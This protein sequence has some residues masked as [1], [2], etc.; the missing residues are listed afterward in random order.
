[1]SEARVGSSDFGQNSDH[2][3]AVLSCVDLAVGPQF[4]AGY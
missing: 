1:M 3:E 4:G 2:I